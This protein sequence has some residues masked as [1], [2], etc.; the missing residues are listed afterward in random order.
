MELILKS[1][2]IALV[3][4]IVGLIIK[5]YNPEISVLLSS[6]TVAMIGIAAVSFAGEL[7][8][9]V[10]TVRTLT[11][12]SD[13]YIAPILKCVGIAIVTKLTAELCRD[14]SQSASAAAVELAGTVCAMSVAMPLI[15]SA[16]E[17]IGGM[18]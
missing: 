10:Y 1:A 11:G 8:S 6:C 2:A 17:M 13:V 5:R 15:M 7:K 9:F 4:A 3:S 16:L 14:S 18:V 12:T